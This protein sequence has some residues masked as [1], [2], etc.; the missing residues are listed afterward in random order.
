VIGMRPYSILLA[1]SISLA[2]ISPASAQAL[3]TEDATKNMRIGFK[4]DFAEAAS[5]KPV[6]T[7]RRDGSQRDSLIQG[8]LNQPG[9]VAWVTYQSAPSF[10]T[11]GG[12][13]VDAVT[14]N[15]LRGASFSREQRQRYSVPTAW[16]S[17]D[18]IQAAGVLGDG[19]KREC[20]VWLHEAD[21]SNR[22]FWG[23]FCSGLDQPLDAGRVRAALS[24]V[25]PR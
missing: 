12:N 13:A 4:P 1:V 10:I 7:V 23:Y 11:Y 22:M 15:L 2:A 5:F 19:S 3:W 24:G 9:P 25:V 8:E 14:T 21:G 17:A 6:V 16:G 20:A 18:V